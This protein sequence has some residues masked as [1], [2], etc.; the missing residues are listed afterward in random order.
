MAKPSRLT[1]WAIGIAIAV[2][3][4]AYFAFRLMA[5]WSSDRPNL[6]FANLVIE[7]LDYLRWPDF[8]PNHASVRR[9]REIKI[10]AQ[11]PFGGF[12][13]GS[14]SSGCTFFLPVD[15]I[16]FG[17][18]KAIEGRPDRLNDLKQKL[19]KPCVF[20]ET[21]KR[22]RS[23]LAATKTGRPDLYA[24]SDEST[25]RGLE[26]YFGCGQWALP[27][28]LHL[29]IMENFDRGNKPIATFQVLR[30]IELGSP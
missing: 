11:Y 22:R 19:S 18:D 10:D 16:T 27:K 24:V 15:C 17:V 5:I 14:E 9:K 4:C 23:A 29:N 8:V 20:I 7:E 12:G 21:A 3:A 28:K 25:L 13:Y 26:S 30:R 2:V 6:L 1:F